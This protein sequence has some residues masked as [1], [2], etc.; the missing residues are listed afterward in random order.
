MSGFYINKRI[1]IK[2]LNPAVGK[3]AKSKKLLG[4]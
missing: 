3:V 4:C 1:A 2:F